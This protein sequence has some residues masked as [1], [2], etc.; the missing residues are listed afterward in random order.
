VVYPG[1]V[2]TAGLKVPIKLPFIWTAEKMGKC[3]ID[4]ALSGKSCCEPFFFY[5]IIIR[6]L[7]AL[8]VK[9]T[10]YA[11]KS[12]LFSRERSRGEDFIN[13]PILLI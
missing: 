10:R 2:D 13:G 1:P 3:M 8:P 4:F 11:S 7:R 12:Y 9:Y 5:K 6:L